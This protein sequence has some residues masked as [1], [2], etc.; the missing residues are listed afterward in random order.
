MF[1]RRDLQNPPYSTANQTDGLDFDIDQ[2][3]YS[4]PVAIAAASAATMR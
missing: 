3:H 4:G 2:S 1:K